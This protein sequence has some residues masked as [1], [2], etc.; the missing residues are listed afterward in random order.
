MSNI[1]LLRDIRQI[2]NGGLFH[3]SHDDSR[4]VKGKDDTVIKFTSDLQVFKNN[5][6]VGRITTGPAPLNCFTFV[7]HKTSEV[8]DTKIE[9]CDWHWTALEN[10]EIK[11]ALH[12]LGVS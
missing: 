7:D 5:T 9:C 2:P 11:I 3:N 6:I 12:L 1:F 8:Y 4:Y 10:A